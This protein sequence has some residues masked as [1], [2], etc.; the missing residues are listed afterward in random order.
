ML[1]KKWLF[2]I[3]FVLGGCTLINNQ[4]HV[5]R[6]LICSDCRYIDF[7]KKKSVLL[8]D[9]LLKVDSLKDIGEE[10]INQ[11]G[12][13]IKYIKKKFSSTYIAG[14]KVGDIIIV[15]DCYIEGEILIGNIEPEDFKSKSMVKYM[16]TIFSN[17][18]QVDCYYNYNEI[19]YTSY[20]EV[21]GKLLPKIIYDSYKES[22][23]IIENIIYIIRDKEKPQGINFIRYILPVSTTYEHTQRMGYGGI[24]FKLDNK[25]IVYDKK[26]LKG[27][28]TFPEGNFEDVK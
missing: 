9:L 28:S 14:T 16:G 21:N 1:G 13:K 18:K 20:V 25:V 22:I 8:G 12:Y 2:Y 6:K 19:K 10:V 11:Y 15:H 3:T 27:L 17:S 23:F 5:N 7:R 26:K 4:T 24:S